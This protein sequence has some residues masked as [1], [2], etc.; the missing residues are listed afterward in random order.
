MEKYI[1]VEKPK[2]KAPDNEVRI[3][4]RTNI[5][6]YVTYVLAQFREKGVEEITLRS[7]GDAISKVVTVAEVIKCRVKG[8]H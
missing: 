2:E 5:S 1:R 6:N 3:T 4:K 8:I 7:M